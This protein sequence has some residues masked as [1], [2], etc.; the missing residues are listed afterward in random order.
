MPFIRSIFVTKKSGTMKEKK[1]EQLQFGT[2]EVSRLFRKLFFPTLLGM[3]F[4]AVFIIT[5]GIFVGRG[6]GSDALAAVNITSPLFLINT[7]IALM[8]GVGASVSA[9]IALSRGSVRLARTYITQ[10]VCASAVFLLLLWGMVLCFAPQIAL[11]FGSS[12]RLLPLALEYMRWFLPFFV[13]SALL[14]SGM[15]YV[16]LDGS[17]RYAMICNVVPALV[18]I[19][20]DYWFIF[21][22]KW[23]MMGAALATSLGYILGALMILIYMIRP[24]VTLRLIPLKRTLRGWY[25]MWRH[26]RMIIR[27]GLSSFLCEAAIATMMFVGNY[28]FMYYL[29]EEGVAAFSIAC[30]FFP[31]IFM[32]YNAIA[33]SAQPILSYNYG[34]GAQYRVH[35]ALRQALITAVIA[36]ALCLILTVLY[37]PQIVSWF[38]EPQY[39]AYDLAVY[40]LP[41][42]AGGFI[43]FGV[44]IVCIGYFQSLE[45]DR[46]ALLITLLRGFVFVVL[47]FLLLPL[48]WGT[49]GIWLAVPVAELLTFLFLLTVY[50]RR[51]K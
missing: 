39:P 21:E 4:S 37:S 13:F 22:L 44:N 23:G 7:G 42:F 34:C 43:F 14:N 35:Q 29:H 3:V 49:P 6:I 40:G 32:V 50:C 2:M 48:C 38:L 12:P 30:Y 9:S 25:Q 19:A 17:P 18:N 36:G 31:I 16:R 33:Q 45:R 8:F 15:F 24:H 5:D 26:I 51:Q 10:A 41:L 11:F 46:M 1:K 47:C 28:V 20:L 27:L